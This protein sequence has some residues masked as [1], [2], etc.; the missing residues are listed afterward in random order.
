[1]MML[2]SDFH[3]VIE[4]HQSYIH[5][6]ILNKINL[7]LMIFICQASVCIGIHEDLYTYLNNTNVLRNFP[8]S[9]FL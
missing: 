2:R 1:M 6:W 4:E 7:H 3:V 8:H 9:H 5:E